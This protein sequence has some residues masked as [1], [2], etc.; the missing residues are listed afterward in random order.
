MAAGVADH[1]W[2]LTE[3]ITLLG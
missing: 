2:T 1:L 3:I